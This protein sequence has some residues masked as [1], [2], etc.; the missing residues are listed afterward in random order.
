MNI[1]T[2]KADG[3]VILTVDDDYG[4]TNDGARY[5]MVNVKT[6]TKTTNVEGK[7]ISLISNGSIGHTVTNP[8]GTEVTTSVTFIQT[9]AEQGY[10]MDALANEDISL[11]E[12]SFND[13]TYGKDKEV[14]TNKVT[15][16]IAREGDMN[17]EFAGNT[18]IDN[19]TA[20]CDLIV[21]TR[22]QKLDIENLGSIKDGNK[23]YFGV[24]NNGKAD[25]G[26]TNADHATEVLPD[27]TELMALDINHN[28]RPT[29]ELVDGNH[30]AYAQ[31]EVTV[32][33]AVL[34][35]GKMDITADNIK[36]NGIELKSNK[37]GVVKSRNAAT[38]K[39]VGANGI[40]TGWTIETESA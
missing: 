31:S 39:V 34:D 19:I 11:Y 5:N 16:M 37:D 2:I 26:Y 40:P 21:T 24:R 27:N 28:L 35:N 20:E 32:K 3:R 36:A 7:G 22:G 18:T 33:N 17:V 38:N 9:G 29:Q 14:K 8:D 30:E 23:D 4:K 25:G 6:D 12:N 15:T 1:D 13:A 10:T